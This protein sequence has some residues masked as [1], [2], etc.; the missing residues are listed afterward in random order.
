LY[1]TPTI[2]DFSQQPGKELRHREEAF[3][4]AP[5][6]ENKAAKQW[7]TCA[8][9]LISINIRVAESALGQSR[10]NQRMFRFID[11]YEMTLHQAVTVSDDSHHWT[12]DTFAV[13]L[14]IGTQAVQG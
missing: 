13:H 10:L 7:A 11:I 8:F 2:D 9:V 14:I 6:T 4:W 5:S 3:E 1:R 12:A